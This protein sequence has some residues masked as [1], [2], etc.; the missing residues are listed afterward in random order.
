M[1]SKP[2]LI[3]TI[4]M[5]LFTMASLVD[6]SSAQV[7]LS[8]LARALERNEELL[9]QA[10]DLVRQT[11]SVKARSSLQAATRLH[12]LS[13]YQA[14]NDRPGL[15]AVNAGRAR[16]AILNTINIAKREAKLEEHAMK[17]I[18]RAGVR[19]QRARAA[20]EESGDRD[21]VP[22]RKLIEEAHH[23]LQRS[24]NN[25]QEH[26]FGVALRLANAS[27]ALS[28]RAIKTLT[29]EGITQESVLREIE[30]TDN[31]IERVTSSDR[32]DHHDVA[33]RAI[34]QAIDLQNRAKSSVRSNNLRLA[35]EHTLRAREIALRIVKTARGGQGP[36]ENTVARAIE[37]TDG[38]LDRAREMA[39]E[40]A[41]ERVTEPLEQA[42]QLQSK[43]KEA[44]AASEYA[45]AMRMTLRAREIAKRALGAMK[46]PLDADTVGKTLKQ[47]DTVIETLGARLA[48]KNNDTARSL[49]ERAHNR[50]VNAW[51][52]MEAGELRRALAL[53]KVARNL[54][55]RGLAEIADGSI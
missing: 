55:R 33:A 22:A 42:A 37:F 10:A 8:D 36:G 46:K 48:D 23:Q 47:T 21:D 30:R 50:Q 29:R 28:T 35:L 2:R 11:N 34:E 16:Q 40:Q 3:L 52:A 14:Q 51:T 43:A 4:L 26:M 19:L 27:A 17:A 25:M 5:T 13:K 1:T 53:T 15:A 49:Y 12:E 41:M 9:M 45:T 20:F 6:N 32:L 54:A 24:R 38:L 7:D 31:I 39:R 44:F 18:E